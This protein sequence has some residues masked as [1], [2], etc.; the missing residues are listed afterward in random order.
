MH[1][2]NVPYCIIRPFCTKRKV[3]RY[4]LYY[5]DIVCYRNT[6]NNLMIN[7]SGARAKRSLKKYHNGPKKKSN[8]VLHLFGAKWSMRKANK[9]SQSFFIPFK[10]WAKC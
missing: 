6:L 8:Y 2:F 4:V 10:K 9:F 3:Q 1:A 5:I 7:Q